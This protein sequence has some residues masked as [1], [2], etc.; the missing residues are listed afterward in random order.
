MLRKGQALTPFLHTFR[1]H[2][3]ALLP[4][5]QRHTAVTHISAHP[6]TKTWQRRPR[7]SP[8]SAHDTGRTSRTAHKTGAA[9]PGTGATAPKLVPSD[10]THSSAPVGHVFGVGGAAGAA[11]GPAQ[12]LSSKGASRGSK[13]VCV[14]PHALVGSGG[15]REVS[16]GTSARHNR[17]A[18]LKKKRTKQSKVDETMPCRKHHTRWRAG[19]AFRAAP[20][21]APGH[22][23]A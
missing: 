4:P 14:V 5:F 20:Q 21:P 7:N 12:A 3:R 19:A 9:W 10:S 16:G 13:G 11:A 22:G 2:R 17:Q 1:S 8:R 15:V 23:P 18:F 6:H